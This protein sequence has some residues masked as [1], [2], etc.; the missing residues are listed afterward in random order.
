MNGPEFD[1][2]A[3]LWQGD[4]DS[5][6]Q[7]RMEAYARRARRRGKLLGYLDYAFAVLLIAILVIGSFISLTPLTVAIAVPLMIA[8]TWLT[9]VRRSVR[10]MTNTLNTSD[11]A[12]FLES[13]LRNA[14]ANLR[15]NTIGL[16]SLPF[17]V[18]VA[19]AF[20]VSIRTGGGPAEI[21]E[22][23]GHWIHTGRAP[24]TILALLVWAGLSLRRRARLKAEIR[25]LE[26]VRRGYEAEAREADLDERT[27]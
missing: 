1:E 27:T 24:I 4:P 17:L 8:V 19:L 9:W 15:R 3:A 11:R 18:P 23:L 10:Q 6:D 16:A 12:G 14:A 21:W 26:G 22:A 25:R 2:F 5:L 13:S 20:K 7:A